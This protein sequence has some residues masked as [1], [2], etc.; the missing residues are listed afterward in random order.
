MDTSR[1]FL[2]YPLTRRYY[3]FAYDWRQDNV[4]T[5]GLLH[6]FLDQVRRDYNDPELK[7]DVVHIAW[8]GWGYGILRVTV[9]PA[10]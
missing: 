1:A 4:E 6:A 5:A 2:D 3:V 8:V 9:Q 7:F 10:C